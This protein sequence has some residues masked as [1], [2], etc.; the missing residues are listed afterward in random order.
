MVPELEAKK[1]LEELGIE[2]L[3]ISPKKICEILDIYYKEDSFKGFE[4]TLV[5]NPSLS[6]IGVNSGI[7]E[8]TR[9]NFTCAHELGHYCM[10]VDTPEAEFSCSK[11]DVETFKKSIQPMELRA[12]I[13]AS[14]LLM[15]RFLYKELV[16]AHDPSWDNIKKLAQISQ[17]S[18]TA[19]AK[20]Y[21]DLTEHAC[22]LIVSV[23][24]KI[25]W[26]NKSK[27]FSFYPN[28][29]D[30]VVPYNTHAY[31]AFKGKLPPDDFDT[32]RI[33][34]WFCEARVNSDAEILEWSLPMNSYG[35]VLTLLWDENGLEEDNEEEY[36]SDEDGAGPEW[37]PPTFH[38]SKRK[39]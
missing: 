33:E 8:N 22:V 28:M 1:L 19:S 7:K 34:D 38:K 24:G 23:D 27:Y 12:N 13:F 26:F 35:Q 5:V 11:D 10:D 20:R 31:S 2:S 25:L 30:R 17:T 18:L 39:R 6:Y 37:E 4:G 15:P 3:P 21:V 32:M 9:K 16:D 29:E 14:E 36:C